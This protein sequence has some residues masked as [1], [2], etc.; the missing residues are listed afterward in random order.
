MEIVENLVKTTL[1]PEAIKN[2]IVVDPNERKKVELFDAINRIIP[3][4]FRV[5]FNEIKE[6][7][8]LVIGSENPITPE[9]IERIKMALKKEPAPLSEEVLEKYARLRKS[10]IEKQKMLKPWKKDI[11]EI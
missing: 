4:G 9:I 10:K 3:E 11:G 5:K 1:D 7:W 8:L 2:L 6:S